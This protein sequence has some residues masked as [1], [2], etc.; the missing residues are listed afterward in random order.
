MG[1]PDGAGMAD[2]LSPRRLFRAALRKWYLIALA[3]ALAVSGAWFYLS[4][5]TPLYSAQSLIEMSVRRPRIM[6]QRGPVMDDTDFFTI[7]T[8]EI[9]NTRIQKFR[10]TEMREW[11][12][13][14]LQAATNQPPWSS[15]QIGDLIKSVSFSMI[16]RSYLMN[17]SCVSSDPELAALGA[18][19]FAEGTIL[20]SV[21]ENRIAS[22]SAVAWLEQQADQQRIALDKVMQAITSFREAQHID[23]IQN[24]KEALRASLANIG[25]QLTQIENSR[26]LADKLLAAIRNVTL[27]PKNVANLPDTTPRREEIVES[28]SRWLL[29]TQERDTLLARFTPDHPEMVSRSKSIG[30]LGDQVASAIQRAQSTANANA[31]LLEQQEAGLRQSME[32]RSLAAAELESEIIR[33]QAELG[34]LER[35]KS[36][37]EMS[38]RGLLTRIEEARISAD[39]GTATVKI[40][41]RAPPPREPFTPRR[42]RILLLAVLLGLAG[43][44]G[45][46]L[47]VEMIEDRFVG[48]EDLERAL[49]LPVLGLVPRLRGKTRASIGRIADADRFGHG[50]EAYAG[51]RAKIMSGATDAHPACLLVTSAGPREGKTTTSSNLAIAFARTGVKTLLV[52]FDLRRPK[53]QSVFGLPED[54]P[55]LLNTLGQGKVEDFPRL[56]MPSDCPNLFVIGNHASKEISAAEVM[57]SRIV[58]DFL[59][60]ARSSYELV[61]L[62]SPPFGVV[63]DALVLG[64]MVDG[65]L[66][67]CRPG[68]SHRRTLRG[69]IEEFG[70]AGVPLLGVV[71]NAV[72]FGR[73]SFLSNYDYRYG[74]GYQTYRYPTEDEGK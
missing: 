33:I 24:E 69:A 23:A 39:E 4:R 13:A 3:A 73:A 56:P 14:Q 44:C 5:V 9:F 57:G 60:W 41:E 6:A 12:A 45:L 47:L 38:Y 32:T 46:V 42:L 31:T 20:L 53:L 37:A 15:E 54:G 35:E 34:T 68:V 71:V 70:E 72:N 22:D 64:G 2:M 30:V 48:T 74:R 18:N 63:S 19:V 28:V 21:D 7:S 29:A 67:V 11:V 16:R 10:G 49:S 1:A 8:E 55:C 17:I 25:T 65:V 43:G 52:D 62:D 61:I 58:K 26:I 36:V 50:A 66:F 59:V 51:L 40:V 27:D